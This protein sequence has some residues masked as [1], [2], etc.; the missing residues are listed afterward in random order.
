M[1]P[2]VFNVCWFPAHCILYTA[3]PM[4]TSCVS[5]QTVCWLFAVFAP[6]FWL[7]AAWFT[8]PICTFCLY[9]Y[10]LLNTVYYLA[11]VQKVC[12]IGL[13]DCLCHVLLTVFVNIVPLCVHEVSLQRNLSIAK[14]NLSLWFC[15]VRKISGKT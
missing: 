1:K 12:C 8:S 2:C 14:C 7:L 4:L 15:Q 5:L 10:Q 3:V 11:L 13:H 9:C 6:W